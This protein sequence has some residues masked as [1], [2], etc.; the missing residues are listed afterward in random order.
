MATNNVPEPSTLR[1]AFGSVSKHVARVLLL[2]LWKYPRTVSAVQGLE[3]WF[4]APFHACSWPQLEVS[5][6]ES[7]DACGYSSSRT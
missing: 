6:G 3:P 5:Y 1:S 7:D 4:L 2:Y